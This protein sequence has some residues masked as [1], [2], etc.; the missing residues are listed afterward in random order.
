MNRERNES[1][2]K[3]RSKNLKAISEMRRKSAYCQKEGPPSAS[4]RWHF[5]N[6]LKNPNLSAEKRKELEA[7]PEIL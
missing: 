3:N 7:E 4:K 5:E 2:T 1:E 6:C